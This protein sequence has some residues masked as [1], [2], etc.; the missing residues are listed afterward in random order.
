M[1]DV[2]SHSTNHNNNSCNSVLLLWKFFSSI[3]DEIHS[4]SRNLAKCNLIS[5]SVAT[6][7]F[8]IT[9]TIVF[10]N[11]DKIDLKNYIRL[12]PIVQ[13]KNCKIYQLK[14][15][16][17]M[18]FNLLKFQSENPWDKIR[19]IGKKERSNRKTLA[20]CEWLSR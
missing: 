10:N 7:L 16:F 4:F 18:H 5:T 20:L 3:L 14:S 6:I 17:R 8:R 11:A 12:W 2:T 1:N 15:I 9:I 13:T 19:Q